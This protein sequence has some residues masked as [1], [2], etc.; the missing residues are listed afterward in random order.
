MSPR[1]VGCTTQK[2]DVSRCS[3]DLGQEVGHKDKEIGEW[4]L[5][6]VG[7]LHLICGWETINKHEGGGG[8]KKI[9]DRINPSFS[10]NPLGRETSK[11]Q[12]C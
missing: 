4:G 7:L 5:F 10:N 12:T 8:L 1:D 9:L 3:K 2:I 11:G 6:D